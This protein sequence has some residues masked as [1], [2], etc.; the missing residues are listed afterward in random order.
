MTATLPALRPSTAPK[1]RSDVDTFLSRE[2]VDA[3]IDIGIIVRPPLPDVCYAAFA[4]P[5]G[6]SGD[7]FAAAVSHCDDGIATLDALYERRPPFNPSSAVAEIADLCRQYRCG[8]IAGDRYA[9]QFVVEAFAKEGITYCHS[10]RDRS[11]IYSDAL[12]LFTSGRVRLLDN[13]R[14]VNQP[15]PFH[16][17][18]DGARDRRYRLAYRTHMS[19]LSF[20][21]VNEGR[22][23]IAACYPLAGV[24][25]FRGLPCL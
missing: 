5:S 24:V 6:G 18:R 14:L 10:Q 13:P 23:Q 7:S 8:T 9:A 3:A 11:Q 2:L 25:G 1:F 19:D 21:P 17:T 4:D 16:A 22:S 20:C 12:P 15:G